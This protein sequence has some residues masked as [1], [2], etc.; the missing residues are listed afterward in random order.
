MFEDSGT[1][2]GVTVT[3]QDGAFRA[4]NVFSLNCEFIFI[5]ALERCI[6]TGKRLYR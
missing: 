4:L 2:K 3:T 1:G 6:K 5:A